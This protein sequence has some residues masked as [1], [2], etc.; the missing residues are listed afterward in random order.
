MRIGMIEPHLRCF[1]GIRRVLEFGNRLVD[2]GHSV[3]YFLPDEVAPKGCTWMECKGEVAPMSAAPTAELDVVLFNHELQWHLLD[4]FTRAKRKVFYALHHG[5]AYDKPGSWYS[6]RADVDLVLA[7]SNWTADQIAAQTGERPV[8]QVGG[9]NREHFR[10]VEVPKTYPLLCTGDTVR[11][12]KGTDTI[13][14]AARRLG[15]PLA[16]YQGKGFEQ[17]DLGREY[18]AAEVFVVGSWFEGFCQPGLE[19]L[20]CGT[21]LVTTD[22]GGCLEYAIDEET[23]LVVPPR[24]PVAMADAIARLRSDPALASKLSEAG[25]QKVA[26]DFDWERRTDQLAEILDGVIAGTAS[27]PPPP[28]QPPAEP[29]LSVVTLAWDNLIYTQKFCESVRIQTDV[30]YE[31]IIVDNGSEPDTALFAAQA[32]DTSVLNDSNLGFAKGMNQ[33]LAA[34]TG[35][36][37]AFC[38]N[39]TVLPEKWASRLIETAEAHA[40]SGIIVPA[41]TEARNRATVRDEPGDK[42]EL[43]DPFCAPPGAVLYLMHRDVIEGVGGWGEEYEVA[44]GEDVDL[45]FKVWVNGLDIVYDQRVLVDH[46]GKG[47]ASRLDDWQGLWAKN[48]QHFLDKWSSDEEVPRLERCDPSDF[49]RNRRLSRSAAQWMDRF[50]TARAKADQPTKMAA[51]AAPVKK[52]ADSLARRTWQSIHPRLPED[53]ADR[54]RRVYYRASG[55]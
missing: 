36:W 10:P 32:A 48:R 52:T 42:I 5:M 34:A 33:G 25:L 21:P 9:A 18:C 14:D 41:L 1:G 23:A 30:D 6:M 54:I 40:S 45:A 44:S 43:L 11:D 13:E 39:D 8:V 38:N 20:A 53:T 26:D 17:A 31:L 24:D 3:T 46:I 51:A 19:S 15:L 35:E 4:K 12:W 27:A 49:D 50:F 2:R 29:E 28:Y 16:S 22:N 37:I 7:N 47:S 55:Q